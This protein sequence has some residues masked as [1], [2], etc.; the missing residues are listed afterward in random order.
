M[1]II[2]PRPPGR[3]FRRCFPAW[4]RCGDARR[5]SSE[6]QTH[7]E[8][9]LLPRKCRR[10]VV[11]IGSGVHAD[12][13]EGLRVPFIRALAVQ[14]A[15]AWEERGI[16]FVVVPSGAIAAG[17]KKMGMGEK[18][19]T[20]ALKQAAAAVGQASLR[21]P[22]ERGFGRRGGAG[23]PPR[24]EDFESRERY[25]NARSTIETLLARGI[26]PIINENDTVATEEIRLGG[27]DHLAA[28]VPQ[29]LGAD[30]LS[31]LTDS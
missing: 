24:H 4:W 20:V 3:E 28:P 16:A 13:E 30:L 21:E 10:S 29:M 12:A 19:R 5:M 6:T 7:R 26:V 27:N 22:Y 14:V 18:P 11:K 2:F 15:Q 25:N 8:S 23:A 1:P 17:R 31:L 9:L